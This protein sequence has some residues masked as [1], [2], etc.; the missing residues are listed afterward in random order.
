MTRRKF[1]YKLLQAG[2][3]IVLGVAWLGRKTLPSKFVWAK[4][5]KKYPGF[6]KPLD[7]IDKQSKWSG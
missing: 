6:V 2:S 1:I 7:N 5:V 4:R 3:A